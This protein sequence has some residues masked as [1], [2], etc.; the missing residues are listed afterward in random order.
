MRAA[1]AP[2][3]RSGIAKWREIFSAE[4]DAPEAWRNVAKVLFDAAGILSRECLLGNTQGD[5]RACLVSPVNMLF[6]M[7]I[8][9]LLKGLVVHRKGKIVCKGKLPHSFTHHNIERLLR[10]AEVQLKENDLLL[11]RKLEVY[12][13]WLGKYPVPKTAM[14]NPSRMMACA[15]MI[16]QEWDR[17]SRIFWHINSMYT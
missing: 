6:G 13:K 10:E 4:A 16:P 12:V 11:L 8:E 2:R 3:L 5:S 14:E 1:V 7:A 17:A 15:T 9:T